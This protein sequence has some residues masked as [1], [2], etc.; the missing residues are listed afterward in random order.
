MPSVYSVFFETAFAQAINRLNGTGTKLK[1]RSF[2]HPPLG[3]VPLLSNR[4]IADDL[5]RCAVRQLP[6][7]GHTITGVRNNSVFLGPY[8]KS[9]KNTVRKLAGWGHGIVTGRLLTHS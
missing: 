8:M 2:D 9:K 7:L 5:G 6:D 4:A 3:D 1:E